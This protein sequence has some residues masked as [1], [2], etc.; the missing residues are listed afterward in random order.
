MA[1]SDKLLGP[2][3]DF[4][5]HYYQATDFIKWFPLYVRYTI[6]LNHILTLIYCKCYIIF[7]WYTLSLVC[8]I[9]G[10]LYVFD[11]QYMA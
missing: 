4:L 8:C 5:T 2:Q 9:Y 1:G 3:I 7:Q 11:I 6:Q 10:I